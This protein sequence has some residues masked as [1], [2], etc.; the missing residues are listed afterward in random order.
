MERIVAKVP[1]LINSRH[2]AEFLAQVKQ[3]S[4]RDVLATLF[5]VPYPA[6][7][8]L[9]PELEGL[10]YGQ[11]A[12]FKQMQMAARGDGAAFDRVLDRTIGKPVNTQINV[13]AKNYQDYLLDVART[14]GII[15]VTPERSHSAKQGGGAEE[16]T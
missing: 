9:E 15:D 5:D 8:L 10:T 16:I 6:D 3:G 14:E 1:L 12:C 2:P 13:D 11:V 4:P 7:P